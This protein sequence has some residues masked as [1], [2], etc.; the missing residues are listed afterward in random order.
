MLA[1]VDIGW[2]ASQQINERAGKMAVWFY[3]YFNLSCL[4]APVRCQRP[5]F[6]RNS[7]NFSKLHLLVLVKSILNLRSDNVFLEFW[8]VF[9]LGRLEKTSCTFTVN[10]LHIR[11]FLVVFHFYFSFR[12]CCFGAKNTCLKK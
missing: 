3:S 6:S 11:I 4:L 12:N 10:E 1:L 7:S 2:R 5:T 9:L 8:E